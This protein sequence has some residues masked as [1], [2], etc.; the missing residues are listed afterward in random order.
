MEEKTITL[1]DL[2]NFV[3]YCNAMP[4][5][6]RKITGF[7]NTVS[8]HNEF[9]DE[10][11][12]RIIRDTDVADKRELSNYYYKI[13]SL[14]KDMVHYYA[15]YYTG[16][17]KTDYHYD[18]F[19]R[20]EYDQGLLTVEN[21]NIK[22]LFNTIMTHTI[23]NGAFF[24]V[25]QVEPKMQGFTVIPVPPH[26]CQFSGADYNGMHNFVIDFQ[27]VSRELIGQDGEKKKEQIKDSFPKEIFRQLNNF[28]TTGRE[29]QRYF[30]VTNEMGIAMRF[31]IG[32]E[33]PLLEAI[34]SI[35]FYSK[36]KTIDFL[37]AADE[38]RKVLVHRFPLD[39]EGKPVVSGPEL[40]EY[41][42]LLYAML[43]N[44]PYVDLVTTVANVEKIQ[45]QDA[46]SVQDS[47]TEKTKNAIYDSTGLPHMLFS[48]SGNVSLNKAIEKTGQYLWPTIEYFNKWLS[49][50]LNA[51]YEV[52]FRGKKGDNFFEV[53]ILPISHYNRADYF[54]EALKGAQ[55]GYDFIT[56]GIALGKTQRQVESSIKL[57]RDLGLNDLMVPLNTSHTQSAKSEGG[58][59]K[60]EADEQAD[61]TVNNQEK[62]EV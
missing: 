60:K 40:K 33:P 15:N 3:T 41:H 56:P 17:H 49:L 1:S 11:V 34:E 18:A 37:T 13:N 45:L 36:I 9:S 20:Q 26:W 21:M 43:R 24:G 6:F 54:A 19:D 10:E 5:D 59:P 27:I 42:R 32:E 22:I 47:K 14:Y 31:G 55:S 2:E 7:V 53:N 46:K 4:T 30:L 62:G 61:K 44:N 28:I 57:N 38:L 52:F 48:P 8:S 23:V 16:D 35:M 58:A 51:L 12:S 39:K 50:Q 25:I 29:E